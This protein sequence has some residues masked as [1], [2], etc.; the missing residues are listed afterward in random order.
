MLQRRRGPQSPAAVAAGE[1]KPRES[2]TQ[3]DN[4][5]ASERKAAAG[6]RRR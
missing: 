6:G 2:A 5:K 3:R 4:G 1:S